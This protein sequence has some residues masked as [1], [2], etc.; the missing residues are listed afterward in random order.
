MCNINCKSDIFSLHKLTYG[1]VLQQIKCMRSD[2]SLTRPD[3]IPVK[4]IKLVADII[5]YPL[6]HVL[7]YGSNLVL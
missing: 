2:D 4:S 6:T 3:E 5:T 1:E 7:S